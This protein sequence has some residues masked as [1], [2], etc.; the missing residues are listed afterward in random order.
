[1][2]FSSVLVRS[3]NPRSVSEGSQERKREFVYQFLSSKE[4]LKVP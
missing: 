1:M 3:P 4:K 2:L